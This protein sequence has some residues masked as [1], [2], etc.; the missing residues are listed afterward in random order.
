[1]FSKGNEGL[2]VSNHLELAQR[3]IED[4]AEL[5]RVRAELGIQRKALA[6]LED[7]EAGIV[8]RMDERAAA[9]AALLEA[10]K[11]TGL[12]AAAD[13]GGGFVD[14]GAV[15]DGPVVTNGAASF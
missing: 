15:S 13:E 12:A 14:L 9:V 7:R 5:G 3:Q 2:I 6:N 1:L 10:D 4:R 8:E 11:A